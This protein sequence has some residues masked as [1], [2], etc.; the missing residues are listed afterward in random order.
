M[1]SGLVLFRVVLRIG[2]SFE[3]GLALV[4]VSEF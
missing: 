2:A 4:L 3:K 1:S